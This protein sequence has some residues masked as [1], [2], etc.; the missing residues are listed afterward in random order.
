MSKYTARAP[1]YQSET[2]TYLIPLQSDHAVVDACDVDLAEHGW[3]FKIDSGHRRYVY[4]ASEVVN[5]K[6]T[7]YL[8]H[9]LILSRILGRPLSRH[10]MADHINHDTLDNRRCNLRL[11]TSRQ[12]QAN[13]MPKIKATKSGHRGIT[14]QGNRYIVKLQSGGVCHYAGSYGTLE[15]AK[16]AWQA[17]AKELY[18]EFAPQSDALK[19]DAS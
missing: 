3:Y 6:Q 9:R 2:D 10:E 17:K 11:A 18:G 8:M 14:R 19:Q 1:I 12:N 13:Q 7:K 16:E 15:D 5:G 4:G